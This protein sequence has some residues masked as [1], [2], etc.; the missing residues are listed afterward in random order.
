MPSEPLFRLMILTG[1]LYCVQVD[2]SWMHI[3]MEPSPVMQ[4]TGTSGLAS[5]APM[6]NGK[7]TPIVPRPP[8]LTQRRGLSK[9]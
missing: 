1:R 2:S 8:E 6:A 5:T 4:A 3:W 9:R 7:P